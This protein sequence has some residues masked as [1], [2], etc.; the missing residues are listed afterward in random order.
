MSDPGV[1]AERT[2]LAW[3]RTSLSFVAVGLVAVRL[4][5]P[6]SVARA[7]IAAVVPFAVALFAASTRAKR[8]AGQ[9]TTLAALSAGTAVTALVIALV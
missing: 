8:L 6:H 7:A 9:R 2:D 5:A 1:A 3:T 4:V